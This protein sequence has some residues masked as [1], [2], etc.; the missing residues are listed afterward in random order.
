MQIGTQIWKIYLDTCCLSRFFDD[1]TQTRVCRETEAIDTILDIFRSGQ[2]EWVVSKVLEIEVGRNLNFAQYLKIKSLLTRANQT[3]LLTETEELRGS[4]L[5][6]LGFKPFDALHIASA[7]SGT[8]DILLTT[9][10][11][12]L[13]RANRVSTQLR[14]RVENP[15]VWLQEV[16]RNGRARNDR[17]RDL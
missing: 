17:P 3:V 4:V 11:R 5:E 12:L 1:Q 14:V 10:D 9:D 15:Y 2:W 7:E 8:A 6:S 16:I 13:R